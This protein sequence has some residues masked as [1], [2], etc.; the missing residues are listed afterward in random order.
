[1]TFNKCSI[2]GR[3]Y[4]DPTDAKGNPLGPGM[5]EV[6]TNAL[7]FLRNNNSDNNNNGNNNSN[8]NISDNNSDNNNN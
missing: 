8:N 5:E 1:M 4:G 2:Q 6:S 7:T 3:S